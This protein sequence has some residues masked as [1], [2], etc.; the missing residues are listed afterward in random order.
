MPAVQASYRLTPYAWLSIGAALLTMAIKGAAYL[1]SG[2]VGLL[3]DTLESGVNLASALMAL[4]V[5]SVVARPPDEEHAY[6]HGKAEYFSSGVEG[7]LIVIA[8]ATIAVAAIRRLLSPVPLSNIALGLAIAT[9]A[10][11]INLVAARI[12]LGAGRKFRSIALEAD[13]QHLMT[14]VW[15]SAAILAGM[16]VVTISKW[17]IL[18]PLVALFVAGRIA[19]VGVIL[20]RRS[21]LGLMDTALPQP[22]LEAITAIL[23]THASKGVRYHALRSRQAGARYFVSMH[24]QVPG[25]WTV[26]R[27]HNFLEKI[28]SEIRQAVPN[29]TVFTH[30]EPIEDPLS[31][32]D[33]QL[34]R[35]QAAENGGS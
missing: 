16:A 2:S 12:L 4:A 6:G 24:V 27:G 25:K 33:E 5:L 21:T 31:W 20:V 7:T 28:E 34:D 19:W 32:E 30:I 23:E 35:T 29:V 17:Q 9:F 11:L 13:A 26:Q 15:S 8:A 1:V 14:D 10:S 22:E 3:S 18:D